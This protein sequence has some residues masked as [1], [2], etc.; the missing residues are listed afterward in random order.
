MCEPVCVPGDSSYP[1]TKFPRPFNAPLVAP[2]PD[3]ICTL[4][5]AN[6]TVGVPPTPAFTYVGASTAVLPAP[7]DGEEAVPPDTTA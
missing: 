6:R 2:D 4:T 1:S 5:A 7:H 3:K